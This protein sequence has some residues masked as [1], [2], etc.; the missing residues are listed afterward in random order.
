MSDFRDTSIGR[1]SFLGLTVALPAVVTLTTS[2]EAAPVSR[3]WDRW[4]PHEPDARYSVDHGDWDAFLKRY[5]VVAPGGVNRFDYGGVS[6]GD[7]D[8]LDRYIAGLGKVYISQYN[9]DE[10]FAFW[11]NLYNALVVQVVLNHY[12]VASIR[13]ID[14]GPAIFLS[15]PWSAKL[16]EVEEE[17]LSLDDIEH[18][19]LRPIWKEPRLHYVINCAAVGCPQLAPRA[20]TAKNR[21][22]ML[23][24]GARAFINHP[25]G[26]TPL[27][28][29]LPRGLLVSKIYDWYLSDFGGYEGALIDHLLRYAEPALA[30]EIRV[31]PYISEYAYDWSLNDAKATSS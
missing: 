7:R 27:R 12:P 1:R 18:R 17:S 14:I 25:R 22:E 11:L 31:T 20:M 29:G 24:S 13:D 8:R 2:A 10:Q 5:L 16:I 28:G 6:G 9:R 26:V 23:D 4:L 30:K 21:E 19:I 3:L 15:G